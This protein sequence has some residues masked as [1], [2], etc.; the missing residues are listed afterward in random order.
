MSTVTAKVL[1]V[2]VLQ[3]HVTVLVPHSVMHAHAQAMH[4]VILIQVGH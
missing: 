1:P 3:V 2:H 4:H